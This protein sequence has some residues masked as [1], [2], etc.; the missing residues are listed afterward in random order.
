MKAL[1]LTDTGPSIGEAAR[2]SVKPHELLVR[3]RAAALNRADLAMA[4]GFRHGAAGGVGQVLGMEWAGERWMTRV[5]ICS[6]S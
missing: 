1:V 2:P 3:V 6:R 4:A 5:A